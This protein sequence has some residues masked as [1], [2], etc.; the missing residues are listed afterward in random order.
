MKKNY[1][2]IFVCLL[3]IGTGCYALNIHS[4]V[5]YTVIEGVVRDASG[6]L[7]SEI[8]VEINGHK[9]ETDQHGQFKFDN[10]QQGTYRVTL[11]GENGTGRYEID[12]LQSRV[13]LDLE[14]PVTTTVVLLHDNDL[15]F[16]FNQ[17]NAFT[18]K[19]E[20]I[21]A[22]YENV[23]LL[24]A[25]DTFVRHAHRWAVDDTMYYVDRSRYMIE[26][27][28]E[29]GYDLAVPGNHEIDYVGIHSGQS[30][31]LAEFTFIAANVDIAT[32]KLP[33]FKPF[34][35]FMTRN[36]LSVAIMGLSTVNFDKPGVSARDPVETA[37]SFSN[38]GSEYNL[39]VA[40]THI[41]YSQDKAVAEAVPEVD[42]IVGGHSHTLLEKA[43]T[44]NG[45]LI[46]QAGGPPP[47]HQ[48]DPD[49]PKYLGKIKV[50]FENET[51][52]EKSGYVISICAPVTSE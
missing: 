42:V 36:G 16:N 22:G 40:L 11:N 19:V 4:D 52:V 1:P 3:I 30:L 25:G 23:W 27:M 43:E 41:G 14:Y 33:Y 13:L 7:L 50:V 28:N 20:E 29:T 21:R 32:G 12:F 15:H 26:N 49:W 31:E 5:E 48:I 46:A 17:K 8:V 18:A 6:D 47:Q 2:V 9:A 37:M 10:L 44:V 39:F 24:N 45:V 51:V 38:L 35:V 34:E